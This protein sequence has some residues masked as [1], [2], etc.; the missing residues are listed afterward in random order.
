MEFDISS[1]DKACKIYCKIVGDLSKDEVPL[2]VLHGGP[3]AGYDYLYG[4]MDLWTKYKIPVIF[5]DQI[6]NGRSK[7]LPETAGD[8]PF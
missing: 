6:G 8:E 2:L 5:Y 1:I 3:G 7:H 4:L